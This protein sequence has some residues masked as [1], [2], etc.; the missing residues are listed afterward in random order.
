MAHDRRHRKGLFSWVRR[1][2]RRCADSSPATTPSTNSGPF[3]RPS[4]DH[5]TLVVRVLPAREAPLMTPGQL[6][7]TRRR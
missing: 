7:R 6:W 3:A 4:W 2:G 5:A 1:S